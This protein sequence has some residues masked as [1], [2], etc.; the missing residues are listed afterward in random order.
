MPDYRPIENKSQ[1]IMKSPSLKIAGEAIM[2]SA[3]LYA[4]LLQQALHQFEIC[5]ATN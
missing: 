5:A 3:E 1:E 2:T 4:V